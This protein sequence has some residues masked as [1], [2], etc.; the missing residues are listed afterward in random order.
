MRMV[1]PRILLPWLMTVSC[2]LEL[3]LMAVMGKLLPTLLLTLTKILFAQNL[4][5]LTALYLMPA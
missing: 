3:M 2:V 5:M 4:K 1:S